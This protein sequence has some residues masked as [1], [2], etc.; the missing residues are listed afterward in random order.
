MQHKFCL[1]D[2]AVLMIGT[3]DWGN[4]LTSDN[5]NYV[6]ITSKPRLVEPVKKEFYSLWNESQI[7]IQEALEIYR[8]AAEEC[9][10]NENIVGVEDQGNVEENYEVLGSGAQLDGVQTADE[11][12]H[13]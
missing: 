7:G 9:T 1:I 6:Y 2:D 11:A 4:D 5:W 8:A 3:L 12:G 13:V 10:Q